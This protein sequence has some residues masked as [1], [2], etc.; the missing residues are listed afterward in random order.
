MRHLLHLDDI[1]GENMAGESFRG[2]G[3][4]QRGLENNYPRPG[5][6]IY[7]VFPVCFPG[8]IFPL[9]PH[10]AMGTRWH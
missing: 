5:R 2:Q 1:F 4:P 8:F 9:K 7:L 3:T 6:N 10:V